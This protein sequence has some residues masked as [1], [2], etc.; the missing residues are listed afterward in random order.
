MKPI[1][2]SELREAIARVL[3]TRAQEGATPLVT[4]YS[5]GVVRHPSANLRILLAED[6]AVNQL[7][8]TRLL[9]KRGHR[10]TVVANGREALEALEKD[11]FDLALMDVQMPELNG[12][13]ATAV[14]R[15]KEKTS[16][17][18][19]TVIAMTAHAMAGDRERCL[20]AGMDD[21]IAKPI[22]TQELTE[23]LGRH[24]PAPSTETNTQKS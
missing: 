23:L 5:L 22:R 15:E 17:N 4:R 6:N 1:L 2:Q 3:G 21:Y 11:T 18:H 24:S 9:V 12:F 13:E 8:A 7:L 10:V 20:K 14:I 19:L 16:G